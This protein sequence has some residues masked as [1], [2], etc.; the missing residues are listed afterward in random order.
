MDIDYSLL[1]KSLMHQKYE[2]VLKYARDVLRFYGDIKYS[3]NWGVSSEAQFLAED[4]IKIINA[5]LND[6]SN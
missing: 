3:D 4:A 2:I 5:V 6:S 1:G